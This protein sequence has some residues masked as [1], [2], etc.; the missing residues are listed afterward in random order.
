MPPTPPPYEAKVIEA[1]DECPTTAKSSRDV[2]KDHLLAR[3]KKCLNTAKDTGATENEAKVALHLAS[4]LVTQLNMTHAEVLALEKPEDQ[5]HAGQSVVAL[6]RRDGDPTK[7]VQQAYRLNELTHAMRLFFD[8]KCFTE[9]GMRAF[10]ISFYGIAE[11]TV[12][13]ANAFC[14]VYNLVQMWSREHKGRTAQNSYCHGV[15]VGL[16]RTGKLE[17]K[18]EEAYAEKAEQERARWMFEAKH[19]GD[20]VSVDE[21]LGERNG[22]GEEDFVSESEIADFHEVDG[23]SYDEAANLNDAGFDSHMKSLVADLDKKPASAQ[24][25]Q[26][27]NR[28]TKTEDLCIWASHKQ[29]VVFRKTASD[30]ADKYLESRDMK[31]GKAQKRKAASLDQRAFA[32]GRMDSK[33]IDVRQRKMLG[34]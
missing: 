31:L 30:I 11:N 26:R 1:A 29:L 33:K 23:Q 5:Q 21:S 19:A 16:Q 6:T 32:Q 10:K 2:S 25:K 20:A 18:Q 22:F 15:S 4:K 3:V 34:E 7:S 12:A 28:G 13:A 24:L 9:S 8:C 17:R 27:Q 14:M